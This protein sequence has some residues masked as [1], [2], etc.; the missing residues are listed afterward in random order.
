M[1]LNFI[2][3]RLVA[4]LISRPVPK[5]LFKYLG[6]SNKCIRL[7]EEE[8]AEQNNG[9]TISTHQSNRDGKLVFLFFFVIYIVPRSPVQYESCVMHVQFWVFGFK[10]PFK[11]VKYEL[12]NIIVCVVCIL[13]KGQN[14]LLIISHAFFRSKKQGWQMFL[15]ILSYFWSPCTIQ[16]GLLFVTSFYSQSSL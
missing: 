5:H 11:L 9:E 10:L 4:V 16:L 8:P 14:F 12:W 1:N 6:V 2:I 3:A 15:S 13:L 7:Q